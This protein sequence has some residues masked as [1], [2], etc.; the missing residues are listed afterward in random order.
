MN[1]AICFA[2]AVGKQL[3]VL[4]EKPL[5]ACLCSLWCDTCMRKP[6]GLIESY[7]VSESR[8]SVG[9]INEILICLAL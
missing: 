7:S 4:D 3:S 5:S 9:G 1:Q 6:I 8:R 2:C